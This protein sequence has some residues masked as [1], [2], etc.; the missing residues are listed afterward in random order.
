MQTGS[1]FG[2]Q[3]GAKTHHIRNI[4]MP[5]RQFSGGSN[6]LIYTKRRIRSGSGL[7]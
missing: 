7:I 2:P 3:S 1:H 6:A 4:N 5:G